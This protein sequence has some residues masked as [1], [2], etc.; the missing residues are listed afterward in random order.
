MKK[1]LRF[2]NLVF[3]IVSGMLLLGAASPAWAGDTFV[4]W[5]SID[6]SA[7]TASGLLGS[8]SVTLTADTAVPTAFGGEGI[9]GAVTNRSV[10]F[11]D[12][13]IFTPNIAPTD[14]I[15]LGAASSFTLSF[16]AP[17]TNP[18]LHIIHLANNELSFTDG[19]A[20]LEFS[21]VSSDG[22]FAVVTATTI[23]GSPPGG[24]GSSPTDANGSIQFSGAITKISWTSDAF[25]NG[26]GF[27]IQLSQAVARKGTV[28]ANRG[29]IPEQGY[30]LIYQLDIPPNAG[31]NASR[32]PYSIDSTSGFCRGA[33]DRVA[34]RMEL[35][36]K[37]WVYVS[38]DAFTDKLKEIGVPSNGANGSK[39]FF[40][41][42]VTNMNI[43]SN[44]QGITTGSGIEGNIEFW[45]NN[46]RAPNAVNVPH[47]S[48]TTWDTGDTRSP[49][50]GYG[51]MQIHNH[52]AGVDQT[53]M[54]Y[55]GWGTEDHKDDLGLGNA[56]S[57]QPDWTFAGNASQYRSR[58]LQIL[59]RPL[60]LNVFA[61]VPEAMEYNLVYALAIPNGASSFNQNAI[62]YAIDR[63]P[64]IETGP[65][66]RITRVAYYMELDGDW[67]YVSMDALDKFNNDLTKIGVPS[68]GPNGSK[69]FFQE[70]VANM[71]VFSSKPGL[72][73]LLGIKGNIEF[74]PYNYGAHNAVNVPHASS[75]TWDIGDARSSQ[76]GY[77]SMQ[78]H[79]HSAGVNQTLMAYNGWGTEKQ[80]DVGLGNAPSGGQ[81]DWTFAANAATYSVKKLVVLAKVE[82][83]LPP[84]V[85]TDVPEASGMRVVYALEIQKSGA[86]MLNHNPVVYGINNA[87]VIQRQIDRV[88]Y[89]LELRKPGGK[90][91]WVYASLDPF[92]QDLNKI[93]LP[94]FQSGASFQQSVS[95]LNVFSNKAGIVTG[96]G[97]QTGN[98]E[99]WPN[100][101]LFGNEAAVPGA[102]GSKLD[103]GDD[104]VENA[105]QG[106]GSFQIHN[107]APGIQQTLMSYS[108]WGAANQ[109]SDVGLGNAPSGDQ[110]DWTFAN[111]AGDYEVANLWVLVKERNV[112]KQ[113]YL[114]MGQSNMVGSDRFDPQDEV[115]HPRVYMLGYEDHSPIQ[116]NEFTLA[117]A[118]MH[119]HGFL[120]GVGIGDTFGRDMADADPSATVGLIP[121]GISAASI[122]MFSK[123]D[124][125]VPYCSAVV[126]PDSRRWLNTYQ[127]FIARAR[128]AQQEGYEIKGILYHQGES[129]IAQRSWVVDLEHLMC[130]LKKDLG[131]GDIPIL[132]GEL[133]RFSDL[134][135]SHNPLVKEAAAEIPKAEWIS[136][137]DLNDKGDG[138]HF[139][140]ASYREFGHR[141][142]TKMIELLGLR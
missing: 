77:G 45:P 72:D 11:A 85:Y 58:K 55:N 73:K 86:P 140:K 5:T 24:P 68:N 60:V 10:A 95:N 125:G 8:T 82:D 57:G 43:F 74:W 13:Q 17:L 14:G 128:K 114:L 99:F 123:R 12:G 36:D 108:G 46:Y 131:L 9:L 97:L 139:N 53:L 80:S 130:D 50:A 69:T 65:S 142:A 98:I 7:N 2:A 52:S 92:T 119:G 94:T 93:G 29:V 25:N 109:T 49:E 110:P 89:Y 84:R 90:R 126:P 91:E 88:A 76:P 21:L 132:I 117:R 104:K 107:H 38:M 135:E 27:R 136:S 120:A 48:N 124:L 22:N 61:K 101:Y 87:A 41:E 63:S 15:G 83:V 30:Q 4:A 16:S 34:Y 129:D 116:F 102:S 59:V 111:N 66:R 105:T 138:I 39:T 103:T 71:N 70:N 54:A 64:F 100:N 19:S 3:A 127:W 121:L 112:K 79:T 33:F 106:Y 113:A 118:P 31:F 133:G 122:K 141:Y 42:N 28:V 37:W 62:P 75:T 18:T 78:I 81:P 6:P 137:K 40:Q 35:D 20:P 51:S 1:N 134:L 47:A 56:P 44:K 23:K 26:D 67:V 115:T 96:I 32:I